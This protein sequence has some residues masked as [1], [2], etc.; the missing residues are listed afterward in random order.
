MKSIKILLFFLFGMLFNAS[1]QQGNG[2][3]LNSHKYI[4]LKDLPTH[5]FPKPDVEQLRAEDEVTDHSGTA[6]WRFGYNNECNLNM[7][8]SGVWFDLPDGGRLW[9][10]RVVCEEALTVNLTFSDV[11]LPDG[12]ELFVYAPKKDFI[13]GKFTSE[14]LYQGKLGTELIPGSASVVEYY[15]APQ[16]TDKP[17]G[18]TLSTVTHGYRTAGE[19]HL[20]AFGS[21]GNCNNNVNC[22]IGSSWVNERNSVVMLVSGSNGFCTGALVNNVLNDGKPYVLTADHCYSD[23]T[24]WIFR[25]NWQSPD[26]NN[27]ASSPSFQSLSGAV[28]RARASASDFCLVEIT[29]G[30]VGNTVPVGYSPYF[31]GWDNSGATPASAVGIHHP[32]GDIKK[33]SFEY[34]PLIS[35]TFGASPA[36]S[37]WGIT[38]WDTGVTEPGSSGSPIFDQNHRIVGQLHGGASACGAPVLS[39]EYGKFSYSWNPAG[40][41][42]TNQLKFWLDPNS[43]GAQFVDGYDPTG[44][45]SAVLDAGLSSPQGVSGTLCSGSIA[46]QVT[47]FNSGSDVLT[48]AIIQYGVDGVE[49]QTYNWSGALAQYQTTTVTLPGFTVSAGP[50]SFSASVT[51]PNSGT[52]ENN[53]NNATVSSFT[54]IINGESVELYFNLDC[55]GSETSWSLAD[56]IIGTI[57]FSGAGYQNTPAGDTLLETFCL[58]EGCYV[59]TLND[60][61]GDGLTGCSQANGGNGN[62]QI[63]WNGVVLAELAEADAD[64]GVQHQSTFC[65]SLNSILDLNTA[66][67]KIYP[68]PASENLTVSID[69]GAVLE[70]ITVYDAS[71]KVH[72]Q[73]RSTADIIENLN[74]S[75]LSAGYY[76]I[77]VRTSTGR[78]TKEFVIQR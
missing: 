11:L 38:G 69:P 56:E 24:S 4:F 7:L 17:Y 1:A 37:H 53:L 26:C 67:I 13:L 65:I 27:P 25:F 68:N 22:P 52:D 58:N 33:I 6:P 8:N 64:F 31:A 62:Y 10:L 29:G 63:A 2:G 50:H 47:I 16:N 35:T 41:N 54:A 61:Y 20:K 55:W 36:N 78:S 42:S 30:L 48:S 3:S 71:G 45:S 39:D 49:N 34:Q 14:H 40:S 21:S 19:F 15:V 70:E 57:L 75:F 18:L 76:L 28:L 12:N 5:V 77:E 59:F 43:S 51:A 72:L 66:N 23:P 9:M 46:P 73:K 60:D 74:V 32:S 44:A